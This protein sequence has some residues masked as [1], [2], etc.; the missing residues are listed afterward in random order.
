MRQTSMHGLGTAAA[1]P[2]IAAPHRPAAHRQLLIRAQHHKAT[3]FMAA[4]ML[5]LAISIVSTLIFGRIEAWARRGQT[6]PGGS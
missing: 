6:R 2:V 1:G 5:Y 3:F 4:G